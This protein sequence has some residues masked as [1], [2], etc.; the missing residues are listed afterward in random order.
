VN[1]PWYGRS[2]QC[3]LLILSANGLGWCGTSRLLRRWINLISAGWL[4]PCIDPSW[5]L[6]RS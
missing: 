5:K 2:R 1:R 4:P 6:P 3:W